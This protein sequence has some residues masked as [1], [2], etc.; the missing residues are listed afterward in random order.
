M[1]NDF[2]NP[3]E[4]VKDDIYQSDRYPEVPCPM[5]PR[6]KVV[7]FKISNERDNSQS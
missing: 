6:R 5:V 1:N 3:V 7:R 2:F 4:P